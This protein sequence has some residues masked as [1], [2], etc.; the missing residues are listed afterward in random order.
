MGV[1]CLKGL[2][3]VQLLEQHVQMLVSCQ[4]GSL[5][6]GSSC[7]QQSRCLYGLKGC[8]KVN[9]EPS[10]LNPKSDCLNPKPAILNPKPQIPQNPFSQVSRGSR[11]STTLVLRAL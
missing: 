10:T 3:R 4:V 9:L 2:Y 1:Y 8:T 6:F 5:Y 11:L 7:I